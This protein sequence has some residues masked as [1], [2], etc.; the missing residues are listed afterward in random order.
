MTEVRIYE[1]LR[2]PADA[3][4]ECEAHAGTQFAPVAV[5]ALVAISLPSPADD[6]ASAAVGFG[7]SWAAA[8]EHN[9]AR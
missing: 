8:S 5:A 2:T 4:A 3:L 1:Q 9:G 6:T 7:P